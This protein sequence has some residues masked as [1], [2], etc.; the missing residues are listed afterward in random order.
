[1]SK[2][3]DKVEKSNLIQNNNL[4]EQISQEKN[5]G[6]NKRRRKELID[7]IALR[8]HLFLHFKFYLKKLL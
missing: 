2:E 8:Y 6:S 3:N 4:D 7:F 5:K 1:M